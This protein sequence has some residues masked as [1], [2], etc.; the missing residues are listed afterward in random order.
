M[1]LYY[2]PKCGLV[3]YGLVDF[4][5]LFCN[6]YAGSCFTQLLEVPAKAAVPEQGNA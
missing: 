3:Y 6:R 1:K 2:C 5:G 4:G